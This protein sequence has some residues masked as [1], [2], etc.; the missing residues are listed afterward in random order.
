MAEWPLYFF[1]LFFFSF[2]NVSHKFNITSSFMWLDSC[3]SL[4]KCCWTFV[5]NYR[6]KDEPNSSPSVK[7]LQQTHFTLLTS[8]HLSNHLFNEV[9]YQVW[10]GPTVLWCTQQNLY[11]FC[12][13]KLYWT[14]TIINHPLNMPSSVSISLVIFVW[15]TTIIIINHASTTVAKPQSSS[16]AQESKALNQ[17]QWWWHEKITASPCKWV[18]IVCNDGGSVIEFNLSKTEWS[19]HEQ[20]ELTECDHPFSIFVFV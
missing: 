5:H 3:T 4:H 19:H 7:L 8:Q 18:G 16:P 6:E 10:A 12:L 17:T 13:V 9:F 1:I 14:K 20:A 2:F 11:L 15:I